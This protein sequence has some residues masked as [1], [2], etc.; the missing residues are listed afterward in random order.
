MLTNVPS[1]PLTLTQST[2]N[3]GSTIVNYTSI[4]GIY[5]APGSRTLQ[6]MSEVTSTIADPD[7]GVHYGVPTSVSTLLTYTYNTPQDFSLLENLYF[8]GVTSNITPPPFEVTFNGGGTVYT[9]G[10][11]GEVIVTVNDPSLTS[12]T[13]MQISLGAVL[14]PGNTGSFLSMSSS[15]RCVAENSMILTTEGYIPIQNIKRGD[16][17]LV[18]GEIYT[19]ARLIKEELQKND[20]AEIVLI[21]KNALEGGVPERDTILCSEHYIY[22]KNKRRLVKSL[23]AFLD[24]EIKKGKVCDLLPFASDGKIYFYDIQYEEEGKYI[25]N[26]LVSQSR[27]PFAKKSPLVKELYFNKNKYKNILVDNTLES[28]DIS[29]KYLLPNGTE[30]ESLIKFIIP[31]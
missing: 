16:K 15:I 10:G 30:I 20:D 26:N 2:S 8:H 25:V 4:D 31:K 1:D 21:K 14:S 6:P 19:V 28:S 3:V 18:H 5:P 29:D 22:Y 27:S 11:V 9:G 23:M 24:I 7:P 12:V 13:T 17:C